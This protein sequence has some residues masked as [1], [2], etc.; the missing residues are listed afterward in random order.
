VNISYI[1]WSDPF[2]VME[3]GRLPSDRV[4]SGR[5]FEGELSNEPQSVTMIELGHLP[6]V[7]RLQV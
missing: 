3:W 5:V 4:Y 1:A 6:G 7:A 2:E